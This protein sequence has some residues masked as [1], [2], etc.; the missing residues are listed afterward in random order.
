MRL[1]VVMNDGKSE[2]EGSVKNPRKTKKKE[3]Y[4]HFSIKIKFFFEN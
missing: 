1:K 2:Y 4:V 3:L